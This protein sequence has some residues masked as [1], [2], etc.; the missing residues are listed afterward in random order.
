MKFLTILLTGIF[1]VF[2]P[3]LLNAGVIEQD[4]IPGKKHLGKLISNFDSRYSFIDKETVKINGIKL[5]M[6]WN[7]RWR[8]GLGIYFL[9]NRFNKPEDAVASLPGKQIAN[10]RFRYFVLYGE[11]IFLQNRKW[12]ISAPMQAGM[13]TLYYKYKDETGQQIKTDR[14]LIYLA[15]PSVAA[16]YKIFYWLGIGAGAGYRQVLNPDSSLAHDLDEPIYYGKVKLF[17]GE[18]YKEYIKKRE[19]KRNLN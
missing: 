13:G 4:T 12:E 11:Y 2:C 18:L 1:I 15:E 10:L 5:G 19:A 14:Q 3:V 6:E 17:L 9:S 8:T 7:E 16:H